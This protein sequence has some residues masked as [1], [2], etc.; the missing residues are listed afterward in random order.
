MQSIVFKPQVYSIK[1]GFLVKLLTNQGSDL[2][3]PVYR[4]ALLSPSIT[5]S[6]ISTEIHG[7]GA[8]L[9]E[10]DCSRAMVGVE[11]RDLDII[12]G[13]QFNARRCFQRYGFLP[14]I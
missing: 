11:E 13:F 9:T 6:T 3:S 7:S 1:K 5:M 8:S 12:S 14:G 10:H 2:I 4:I